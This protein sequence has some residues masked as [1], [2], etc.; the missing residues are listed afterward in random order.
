[1][2]IGNATPKTDPLRIAVDVEVR[3]AETDQM[4]HVHHSVHVVWFE[5]ARTRLCRE[6]EVSY[7]EIEEM[8]YFL[9]VTGVEARY[10][11]PVLYGGTVQVHCWLES[12]A[13][14]KLR[15]AY[16]IEQDGQVLATGATE[17]IWFDRE[18]Q[19]PCRIPQDLMRPFRQLAGL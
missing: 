4:G 5:L 1:M 14:R 3:Y 2:G 17:H 6:T 8:G 12:F 10:V 15:F 19:R 18:R 13:S 11:R 16:S 7:Q 9:L